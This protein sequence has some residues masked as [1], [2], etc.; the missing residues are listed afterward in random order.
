VTG[1]DLGKLKA[2]SD[3][4]VIGKDGQQ[5][6]V[7]SADCVGPTIPGRAVALVQD[8]SDA[9][10]TASEVCRGV[11]MIIHEATYDKSMVLRI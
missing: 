4:T 7:R 1:K 9:K 6:V 11:D 2:G 5:R 10:L 8:T 3:V